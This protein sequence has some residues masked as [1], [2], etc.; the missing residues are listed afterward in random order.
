MNDK[1]VCSRHRAHQPVLICLLIGPGARL[2]CLSVGRLVKCTG[3]KD[4]ETGVLETKVWVLM[5]MNL[6][7]LGKKLFVV[8]R[9]PLLLCAMGIMQPAP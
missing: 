5:L 4:S 1:H 3:G 7:T 9:H 2:A 8:S 6:L